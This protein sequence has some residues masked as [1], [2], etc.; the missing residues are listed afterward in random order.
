MDIDGALGLS[1]YA[2]GSRGKRT[3][4]G[5]IDA[6]TVFLKPLTNIHIAFYMHGL[7]FAVRQRSGVQSEVSIA[8]GR[9]YHALNQGS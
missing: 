4:A 9:A 2:P 7:E 8:S 6:F 1:G 5:F 3:A